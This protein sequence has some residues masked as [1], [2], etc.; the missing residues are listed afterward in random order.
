M[1]RVGSL[2]TS[3]ALVNTLMDNVYRTMRANFISVPTDCPQ[4]D[5]RLGWLDGQVILRAS[6]CQTTLPYAH[7]NIIP[8][9]TGWASSKWNTWILPDRSHHLEARRSIGAQSV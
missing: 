4:R 3:S 2:R 5:E 9:E 7:Q 1:R 8:R 6:L